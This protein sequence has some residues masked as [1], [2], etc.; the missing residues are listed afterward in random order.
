MLNSRLAPAGAVLLGF[1]LATT[2]LTLAQ[3]P[4]SFSEAP[5][6][7]ALVDAGSLAPLGE[8]LPEHPQ[9]F[10]GV[11]GAGVYGGMV[12][13]NGLS[14]DHWP[15]LYF[16]GSELL[17]RFD[18][19]TNVVPALA[20]SY[21]VNADATEYTLHLRQGVKWSDG[22]PFTV[23]DILFWYEDF[24]LNEEFNPGKGLN[25]WY[26]GLPP[27]Y[28]SVVDGKTVTPKLE[29][30]DE[31][32]LK[33]T[34]AV[35]SGTYIVGSASA[36]GNA[37]TRLPFHY[38][39]QFHPKY[40]PDVEKLAAAED[41]PDWQS[42]M[43]AKMDWWMNPEVPT[44]HPWKLEAGFG[45][46]TIIEAKRNP[47][48]WK[49]DA[50]GQQ[51]PY[52]DS[53]R[54]TTVEDNE[55][56]LL[57]TLGGEVDFK[58]ETALTSPDNRALFTDNADKGH[59]RLAPTAAPSVV[60]S[61]DLNLT[62]E[63]P[64]KREVFRNKDF[65]IGLSYAMNRQEISD[66]VYLGV[67]SPAQFAPTAVSP[68]YDEQFANQYSEYNQELANQHLDKVLPNK[69]ADGYRLGPDGKRFSFVLETHANAPDRVM[70]LELMQRHFQAVGIETQLSTLDN[71]LLMQRRSSNQFDTHLGVTT[72]GNLAAILNFNPFP[73]YTWPNNAEYNGT[74]WSNWYL[75]LAPSEEPPA[76]VKQ[77]LE[78]MA[79]MRA[80]PDRDLQI[81]YGL[82]LMAISRDLFISMGTVRDGENYAI[83]NADLANIVEPIFPQ[84]FAPGTIN[85]ET[86]FYRK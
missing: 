40:N 12:R 82:E 60:T 74:L 67:K 79:K 55:V 26:G 73:I 24:A 33:V 9:V 56:A 65:R 66:L 3:G 25:G 36:E 38:L 28:R 8:R 29:K 19:D 51:L 77:G 11:D 59:Y 49:V 44:L 2:G 22:E 53:V 50:Q 34:F 61:F 83:V 1:W 35:P 37:A 20:E 17:F 54:M 72:T 68:I 46:S 62:V 39:K 16:V 70:S 81:K 15:L 86:F 75:G 41:F 13:L 18:N 10:E 84:Y 64:I 71:N 80:T 45:T 6:L 7:K 48:Y 43:R 78:V 85:P 69:D 21:E 57:Q 14:G 76:E 47:Y 63:D 27:N 23:D 32:T 5:E 58:F 42:M 52:V 31:F 30:L 4:T